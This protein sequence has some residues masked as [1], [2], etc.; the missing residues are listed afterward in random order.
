M[1]T[2]REGQSLSAR[3]AELR[4]DGDHIAAIAVLRRA[5]DVGEIDAPRLLAL[6]LIEVNDRE[7]ARDV[8]VQAVDGG[9]YDLAG[10]LG[11]VAS[12]LDE[13]TLAERSYTLA[14][15]SGYQAALNDYGCFLR[16]QERYDEAIVMFQRAI[17]ADDDLA[18][19]NL[20]LVYSEDLGD[21]VTARSLGERYADERKPK[22]LTALAS[23]CAEMGELDRAEALFRR[24][25]ELGAPKAH[26]NMG[27]FLRDY[28]H[29]LT[30]AEEEFILAR[31]NDEERWGYELGSLLRQTGR[32]DEAI[33]VL[34]YAA[35]W[36]DIEAEE[37]LQEMT[38]SN[39]SDAD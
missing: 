1:D 28:R 24:A 29:D 11:D 18:A 25:V 5:V 34:E 30:G 9:R 22:T 2:M 27:W 19:G 31:D 17:D 36:G 38:Q 4:E 6:S 33:E 7:A 23:V 32:V 15:D 10:L 12:D 13:T 26:V 20:I 3:G 35:S 21:M 37:L 39:D 14:I 16:D 8:L